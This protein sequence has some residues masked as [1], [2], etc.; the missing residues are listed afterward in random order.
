MRRRNMDEG[1]RRLERDAAGSGA[2]DAKMRLAVARIRAGDGPERPLR[3]IL[4]QANQ[5]TFAMA[6]LIQLEVDARAASFMA[7]PFESLR[8]LVA[9]TAGDPRPRLFAHAHMP[10]HSSDGGLPYPV[11][12]ALAVRDV[13]RDVVTVGVITTGSPWSAP[14]NPLLSGVAWWTYQ[15]RSPARGSITDRPREKRVWVMPEINAYPG[16][17]RQAPAARLTKIVLG[18]AR[19]EEDLVPC[20]G[21]GID[22]P[23]HGLRVDIDLSEAELWSARQPDEATTDERIEVTDELWRIRRRGPEVTGNYLT[24]TLADRPR[25]QK[26]ALDYARQWANFGFRERDGPLFPGAAAAE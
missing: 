13:E 2:K 12:L 26:F 22:F 8:E 25:V 19:R 1:L 18:W 20:A 16:S 3:E 4:E 24:N 5:A 21:S 9:I 14:D 15:D 23:I 11:T 6:R 17:L 7:L 10:V